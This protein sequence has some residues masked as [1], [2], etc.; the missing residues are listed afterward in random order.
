ML[1]MILIQKVVAFVFVAGVFLIY[2]A[3]ISVTQ[4]NLAVMQHWFRLCCHSRYI[5]TNT[6]HSMCVFVCVS[7]THDSSGSSSSSSQMHV[8]I[9]Y[10]KSKHVSNFN[11][12]WNLKLPIRISHA[13]YF[14]LKYCKGCAP[15]QL[16]HF[17]DDEFSFTI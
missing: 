3:V 5:F 12:Q 4:S 10:F 6:I 13:N 11:F 14:Q 16:T 9:D 8:C 7:F 2:S 15:N 17:V 1:A